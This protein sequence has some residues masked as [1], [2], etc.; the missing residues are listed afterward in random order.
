VRH[1][2]TDTGTNVN[3]SSATAVGAYTADADRLVIVD[4][5]IDAVAGAGDYVM[6]VT[7]QI[8][9]SGSAYKILPKTTMTAATG[10]TAIA[11]QSGIISVKSGDVLTCYVDGLAGDTTTP[12][13]TTRWFEIDK[14][15]TLADDAVTEIQSGLALEATLTAIK[16]AGW[17]DE[18]LVAIK[19]ALDALDKSGVAAA[20]WAY[21][22]RTLT[23]S[24]A[25]VAA[26][27]AGSDITIQRGDTA[28][29]ALTDVGAL[30]GYSKIWFTVKSRKNHSDTES[31]IQI[32]KTG[33]L[34]YLNGATATTTSDGNLTV[35]DEATGD[36]TI[37][38][39]AAATADLDPGV[40]YYD[41]Q[42]LTSSGVTTMTTGK[43][44][45]EG[46][47]TRAVA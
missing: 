42:L 39:K 5:M 38:I 21:A 41:V 6:Y 29:I 43:F 47:I 23:Q 14:L 11:G 32:E 19:A 45:V 26:V 40:Y 20:V 46:D 10:E 13:W 12:D 9:G 36:V 44:T 16:G 25:A 27:L 17:S 2:E 30:T 37:M 4:V 24:A 33:G 35:N 18:T 7:K 3:I 34:L 31:I 8:N 22:A 15:V 28:T 1:I